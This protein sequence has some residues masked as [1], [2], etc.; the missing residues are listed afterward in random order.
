MTNTEMLEEL[1]LKIL[2]IKHDEV[3]WHSIKAYN[4][5]IELIELKKDELSKNLVEE[6][7]WNNVRD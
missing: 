7:M 4:K 5:V 3:Q 6:D 1:L 2:E